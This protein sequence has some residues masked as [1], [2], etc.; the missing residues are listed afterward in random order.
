MALVELA[1]GVAR[2]LVDHAAALHRRSRGDRSGPALHMSVGFHVEEFGGIDAL[3]NSAGV[4]RYGTVEELTEE[5]KKLEAE[6]A[7]S[8]PW[9]RYS[10]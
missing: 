6:L 3:Y 2:N 8:V 10:V 7:D 5:Q 4:V 9:F 1:G